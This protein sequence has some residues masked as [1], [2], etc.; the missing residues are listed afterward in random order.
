MRAL[1]LAGL[2]LLAACSQQQPSGPAA[3]PNALAKPRADA[4]VMGMVS[5]ARRLDPQ[6]P[7]EAVA[8]DAAA[9][10]APPKPA[11]PVIAPSLAYTYA[12]QLQYPAKTARAMLARHQ[13]A[14]EDAG[15]ML[16]QVVSATSMASGDRYTA[17]R[18]QI[19]G[20]PGWLRAFRTR[21]EQEAANSDGKVLSATTTTEDLTRSIVDTEAAIRTQTALQARLER[22]MAERT[23]SLRDALEVEGELARV[24]GEI[25]ATRSQLEVMKGRVAMSTLTIDYVT[26]ALPDEPPTVSPVEQALK[27]FGHN[28]LLILA[29]LINIVSILLPLALVV[30][31]IVWL[32]LRWRRRAAAKKAAAAPPPTA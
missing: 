5:D 24:R 2:I 30:V 15:Y 14:C 21:L 19:R 11:M 3:P 12:Y 13:A 6:R 32:I 7:A 26:G 29:L 22:L 31:P 10:T 9:I 18:L 23:G 1:A 28:I 8:A 4:G 20:E 16:C 27:S 17:G 25:D